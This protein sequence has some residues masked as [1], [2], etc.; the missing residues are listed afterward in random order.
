MKKERPQ[1]PGSNTYTILIDKFNNTITRPINLK[2]VKAIKMDK[3]EQNFKLYN[4]E[5]VLPI[6][7]KYWYLLKPGEEHS[8]DHD[9]RWSGML[10]WFIKAPRQTYAVLSGIGF[11]NALLSRKNFYRFQK[12]LNYLQIMCKYGKNMV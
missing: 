2:P 12:T 1:E 11:P 7:G 6:F 9:N 8:E 10:S 4:R 5:E 3:V